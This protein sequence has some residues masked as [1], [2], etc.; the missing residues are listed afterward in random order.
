M[1]GDSGCAGL[2]KFNRALGRRDE[3]V[4]IRGFRIEIGEIES[5]LLALPGVS[6]ATV[7]IVSD[8]GPEASLV[9]FFSAPP[10]VDGASLREQLA[11]T[12]PEYM[13]PTYFHRLDR[14]PLT[15]NGKIDKRSLAA[16]AATTRQPALTS[17][18]AARPR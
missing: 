6:E 11:A 3:Q 9:A 17:S 5:R 2:A 10:S 18:S 12:L 16:L 13:L 8:G 7:V 14:L 4:K 15:E 1:A